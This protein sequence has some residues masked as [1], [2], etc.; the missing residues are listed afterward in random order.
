MYN[1]LGFTLSNRVYDALKQW[2]QLGLPALGTLYFTLSE[3]LGLPYGTEVVGT[4]TALALFGGTILG[5]S[6]INFNKDYELV[7]KELD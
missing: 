3:R 6:N 4:I 1:I 7:Q 2:V 5:I